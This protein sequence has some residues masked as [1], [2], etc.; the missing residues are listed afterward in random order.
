M[1]ALLSVKGLEKTFG[2]VVAARDINVDVPQG[3]TV[4]I[5]GANGAGKTTDVNTV[6]GHL[7]SSEGNI[8]FEG[9]NITG[10]PP[11]SMLPP[12][13]VRWPVI[14][15]TKVVLSAPLAP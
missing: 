4:G 8:E 6:T 12:A 3:Q 14:M 13:G 9:Q 10:L 11:T 15:F 5:I 1:S 7:T 2:Q